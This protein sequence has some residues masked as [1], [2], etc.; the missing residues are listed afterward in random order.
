MA[1]QKVTLSDSIAERFEKTE[2]QFNTN[3]HDAHNDGIGFMISQLAYLESEMYSVPYADIVF[4]KVVPIKTDVPDWAS[5]VNYL[6]YNSAVKGQFIGSHAKDLPSVALQKGIHNVNLGYGGLSLNY[7]LDDMRKAAHLGLN[8][9]A[10][11]AQEAYRGAREHQQRVV[12]YGDAERAMKGFIGNSDVGT[13]TS[14]LATAT[15]SATELVDAIN[16]VISE[17]WVDSKQR[18]LPNTICI[19]SKLYARLAQ[20]R[21]GDVVGIYSALQYI[22]KNSIFTDRTGQELEIIPMPQLMASEMKAA[23]FQE[24]PQMVIY[25]KSPVNL[26]A[27]MPIAPRFIAPQAE[28]LEIITPMEYKI[29]GTEFRYP[30]SA[31]YIKF[32]S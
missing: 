27:F 32:A 12:L 1:I 29:S 2:V 7:S 30:K 18:F 20:T 6:S 31:R 14:S 15:A 10:T 5:N 4:D 13:T 17:I 11:Q 23:G 8:L 22:K 16:G 26:S 25:D 28:G 9:D 19:D 3:F 21:L 24:K